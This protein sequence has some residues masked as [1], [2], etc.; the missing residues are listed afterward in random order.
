MK[1]YEVKFEVYGKKLKVTVQAE[2][3]QHAKRIV[4]Q[5]IIFHSIK[6]LEPI[7]DPD[8]LGDKDLF[9]HLMNIFHHSKP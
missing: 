7:S 4:K 2:T 5:D 8:F 6:E 9:G 3:E 1:Q